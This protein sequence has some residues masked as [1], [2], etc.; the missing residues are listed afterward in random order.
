MMVRGLALPALVLALS[1][2]GT[3]TDITQVPIDLLSTTGDAASSASSGD[4][5]EQA[6]RAARHY[7]R[8]EIDWIRRDAAAGEG[9]SLRAL[10]H[11]L[12]EPDASE[13]SRWAQAHHS[14]LFSDLEHAE[15]LL[16]RIQAS[17]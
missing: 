9:D 8:S 10:A 15:D 6:S 17:R 5:G 3:L 11:L 12:S 2:C 13:F 1:G 4:G 16:E 14:V 7:V